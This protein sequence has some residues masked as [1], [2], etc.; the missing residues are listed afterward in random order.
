MAFHTAK[1]IK[2]EWERR[3]TNNKEDNK[4]KKAREM[5]YRNITIR[6]AYEVAGLWCF[7]IKRAG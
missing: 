6:I 7:Q 2:E 5:L 4:K 1:E 3:T